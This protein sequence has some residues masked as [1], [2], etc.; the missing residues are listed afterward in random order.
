MPLDPSSKVPDNAA[1]RKILCAETGDAIF[2]VNS[3]SI[4]EVAALLGKDF[5]ALLCIFSG[6][7]VIHHSLWLCQP[8]L[9]YL[10]GGTLCKFQWGHLSC[11]YTSGKNDI[12]KDSHFFF[13]EEDSSL[14]R[15]WLWLARLHDC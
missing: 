15:P 2:A 11:K 10:F 8:S 3:C 9:L 1:K 7:D 12:K 4:S 6:E 13:Q 5:E 14:H